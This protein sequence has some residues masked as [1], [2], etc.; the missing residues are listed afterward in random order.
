MVELFGQV[1]D[2]GNNGNHNPEKV[3]PYLDR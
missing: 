3:G 2:D 1:N